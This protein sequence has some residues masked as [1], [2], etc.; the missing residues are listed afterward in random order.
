MADGP[1]GAQ[2]IIKSFESGYCHFT[3]HQTEAK[4][5]NRRHDVIPDLPHVF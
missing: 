4:W 2:G 5:R 1:F 3:L